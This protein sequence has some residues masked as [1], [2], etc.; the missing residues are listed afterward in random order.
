MKSCP[1]CNRTFPDE[2]QKFCTFDG[3]LLIS[4]Q[5]FD[6]NATVRTTAADLTPAPPS[7]PSLP[8]PSSQPPQGDTSR[9]LPEQ[10]ATIIDHPTATMTS[11]RN[12]APTTSPA[13]TGFEAPPTSVPPPPTT[14]PP[15]Q[16]PAAP[17]PVTAA[18]T[19]AVPSPSAS[20][21]PAAATT[22]ALEAAPDTVFGVSPPVVTQAPKKKSK[23]PWI[24]A[25][26]VILLLLGGGAMAGIFFLV[27]KPRLDQSTNRQIAT[28]ENTN[29][30]TATNNTNA[31]AET[32]SS[33]AENYV[34]P[35]GTVEFVNS[36]DNLDGRL[37]EHYIDFS[38]YYPEGWEKDPKAGVPG[39]VNFAR[40]E[41][42]LPPDFTQESFAVGW[43]TSS[44]TF[45]ADLPNF[46]KRVEELSAAL[47]KIYPE[48]EKVSEGP[49]KVNSMDAYEFRWTGLSR[50]TEKGDLQLWGR[51]VFLPTGNEG[52]TTGATLTMFSTSLASEL[53]S[54]D[55]VGD[56]GETPIILE[57]FRFKK[58]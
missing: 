21:T 25:G 23:L 10:Y 35:P 32:S 11:G 7:P 41:R 30:N 56:K 17:P 20:V 39:A 3:G 2:T 49:T 34:A 47:A 6:P 1:K 50:G 12:T 18:P 19:P 5:P 33:P 57:S 52:D 9:D 26:L 13:T 22:P 31:V 16:Q 42:R 36:S 8:A 27:V 28:N 43:Y 58:K 55:D 24:I 44:G 46:P 51:V 29:T 48:Y 37:A 45:I 53:A 15:Q 38:F 54:V 14:I 4:T 40:V